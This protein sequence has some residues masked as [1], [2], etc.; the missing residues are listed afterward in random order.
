MVF[1]MQMNLAHFIMSVK[2]KLSCWFLYIIKRRQKSS[3]SSIAKKYY[4]DANQHFF[5]GC[6]VAPHLGVFLPYP[7]ILWY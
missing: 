4:R 3:T 7:S 2:E 6:E 1:K 5:F